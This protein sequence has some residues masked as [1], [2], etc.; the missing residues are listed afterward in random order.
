[1]S[2]YLRNIAPKYP[3]QFIKNKQHKKTCAIKL[4]LE[5]KQI[6]KNHRERCKVKFALKQKKSKIWVLDNEIIGIEIEHI[7]IHI[8]TLFYK[9]HFNTKLT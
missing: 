9:N 2:Y 4:W 8:L 5:R 7:V 3:I 6:E 1:M